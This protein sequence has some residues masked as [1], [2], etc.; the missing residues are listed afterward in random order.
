MFGEWKAVDQDLPRLTLSADGRARIHLPQQPTEDLFGA[1]RIENDDALVLLL[2]IPAAPEDSNEALREGGREELRF[3]II[4]KSESVMIL[5]NEDGS[6]HA[7]YER[8]TE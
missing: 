5:E 2:E 7:R 6:I 3:K 1:W 4:E 8:V